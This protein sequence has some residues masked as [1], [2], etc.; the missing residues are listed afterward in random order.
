MPGPEAGGDPIEIFRHWW[1]QAEDA[2]VLL[3]ESMTLATATP[4]GRPSAR[5]VLLKGVSEGGFVFFTNYGS[6]KSQELAA[7]PFAALVFHWAV[8][9]RQVRVEGRV[10]RVGEEESAAYFATRPR[11]SQVGAWASR[12]SQPIRQR[13]DLEAQVE[14]I[15][16]RFGTGAVPLPPFWGG[17]RLVPERIEF[18]QGRADRLHDRVRHTR[19]ADGWRAERL[20]P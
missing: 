13:S 10:E 11:G 2:G 18:W 6:R 16:K 7:N 1:R 5:L 20:Q 15:R 9:Q 14:A 8:L 12:Q 4:D 17:Y 3:A 19:T